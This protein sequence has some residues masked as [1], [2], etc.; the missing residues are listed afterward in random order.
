MRLSNNKV[1]LFTDAELF[2]YC[3]FAELMACSRK[4]QGYH[5]LKQH[6]HRWFARLPS[7]EVYRRKLNKYYDALIYIFNRLSHKYGKVSPSYALIDTA[8]I[9]VCQAQHLHHSKATQPFVA[10]GYCA[11]KKKYY[12]GAKLQ[13][14]A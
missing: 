10:K 9:E 2:T 6:F 12:L 3:I 1:P 4:K 14:V 7:Y 11:A 8:P 13:I 5:Y